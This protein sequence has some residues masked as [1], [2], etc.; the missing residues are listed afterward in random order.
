MHMVLW[1]IVA[2]V[3]GW[4]TGNIMRGAGYGVLA[5]IVLGI[6]GAMIGGFIMQWMG[7]AGKGGLLY[8]IGVAIGGAVTL[9]VVVR[10]L[11]GRPVRWGHLTMPCIIK[12]PC[13]HLQERIR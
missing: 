7:Y 9:T 5:D 8:T 3:A 6:T 4:I 12:E 11:T 13:R 2:L 1:L 10:L